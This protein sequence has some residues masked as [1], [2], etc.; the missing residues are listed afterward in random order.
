MKSPKSAG[1]FQRFWEMLRHASAIFLA[2]ATPLYVKAALALGLLYCLSP[3]DLIP[4]YVPVLGVLDDLGLAA[5]LIAWAS[6]MTLP[7][8]PPE[9]PPDDPPRNRHNA[10]TPQ[11]RRGGNRI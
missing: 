2:P 10:D 11:S 4:E 8:T 6:R 1:F 5:L 7:K 3:L 9:T